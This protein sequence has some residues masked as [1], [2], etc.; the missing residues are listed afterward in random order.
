MRLR[1]GLLALLCACTHPSPSY[2]S[3]GSVRSVLRDG[4]S[5]ARVQLHTLDR[6]GL[7]AVGAAAGLDGEITIDGGRCLLSQVRDGKLQTSR[8]PVAAATMLFAAR[9]PAWQTIVV[10][11]D[12]PAERLGEYLRDLIE[13]L[14]LHPVPPVPFRAEGPLLDLNLHVI[15]GQCP[16]RAAHAGLELTS[17][18]Y[19]LEQARGNGRLVGFYAPDGGGQITHHGSS[20]HVHAVLR[21]PRLLTGHCEAVGLAAGAHLYLPRN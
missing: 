20:I 13:D 1:L 14:G 7:V 3:F 15:A 16:I 19:R 21:E 2:F 9:V 5:Q 4:Q 10:E 18:P 6:D 11:Q 8:D 17:P 12:V